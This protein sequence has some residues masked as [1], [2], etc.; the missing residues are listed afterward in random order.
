MYIQALYRNS[1]NQNIS[2]LIEIDG[3]ESAGMKLPNLYLAEG[4]S[5][6]YM[7]AINFGVDPWDTNLPLYYCTYELEGQNFISYIFAN[8][9][10][11]ALD[12]IG[13]KLG[14]KAISISLTSLNYKN[15]KKG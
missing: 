2:S 12:I 14:G 5:L 13:G 7:Q 3:W 10:K 9:I 11:Q 4:Y 8:D 1:S 6:F 15:E